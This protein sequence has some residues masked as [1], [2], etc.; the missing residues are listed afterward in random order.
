MSSSW[1]TKEI[2]AKVAASETLAND[3]TQGGSEYTDGELQ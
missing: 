3:S 2:E 1:S